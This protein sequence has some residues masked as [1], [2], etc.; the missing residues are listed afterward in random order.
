M[1]NQPVRKMVRRF[2]WS[3]GEDT[4]F[5]SPG[6]LPKWIKNS[7]DF[8]PSQ[9]LGVAHDFMEHRLCDTGQWHEELMA[10]GAMVHTRVLGDYFMRPNTPHNL[11]IE[12]AG[13]YIDNCIHENP[14]IRQPNPRLLM[15][16]LKSEDHEQALEFLAG[17]Q[18]GLSTGFDDAVG[19]E[20]IEESQRP[21][22]L[23]YEHANFWLKQGYFQAITRYSLLSSCALRYGFEELE[24]LV[25]KNFSRGEF[26]HQQLQVQMDLET[27]RPKVFLVDRYSSWY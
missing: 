2:V 14:G 22:G 21:C 26:Y 17:I 9:G 11:G 13:L 15:P 23:W 10:F 19:E 16:P 24:G 3:D 5:G 18:D 25:D 12:L 7:H 20:R 6:W 8:D 1:L 4:R 27:G